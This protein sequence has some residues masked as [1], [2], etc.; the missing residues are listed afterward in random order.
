MD[1]PER[2]A[3]TLRVGALL[4]IAATVASAQFAQYTSPGSLAADAKPRHELIEEGWREARWRSGSFRL[5]PRF[6]I[7]NVGY[8]DN[9]LA[10]F[11][12]EERL[13]DFHATFGAGLAAYWRI[14]SQ[15][16]ATAF[17]APEYA[18]WQDLDAL[19]N[20]TFSGGA[21][22]HAFFNRLSLSVEGRRLERER[23]LNAELEV[24]I[25]VTDESASATF[26]LDVGSVLSLVT[27]ASI[28]DIRHGDEIND[29][30][31]GFDAGRL[32]RDVE[33][34]RAGIGFDVG[35]DFEIV[36]GV[37]ELRTDFLI[38]PAGRSSSGTNPFVDLRY[39]GNRLRADLS[40]VS[41]KLEFSEPLDPA[42]RPSA[43]FDETTGLFRL[44]VNL[45]ENTNL[46]FFGGRN[47]VYSALDDSVFFSEERVGASVQRELG[48][49]LRLILL[50]ETGE[51]EFADLEGVADRRDDFSSVGGSLIYELGP[52]TELRLEIYDTR[53][54][55][56]QPEFDRSATRIGIRLNRKRGIIPH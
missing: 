13:S 17:A 11:E 1:V 19:R 48:T 37:E 36:L 40:A 4:W 26:E 51:T 42:T 8:V 2:A 47:L 22:L 56:N 41:R 23:L 50:G 16:Y 15:L 31:E 28:T 46:N 10:D 9:V 32:D 7:R 14:G 35:R 39:R 21:G 55:S 44:A 30:L 33:R 43:T 27:A 54:D 3:K 18:W 38:D 12:G 49:R 34:L 25:R 6:V 29:L 5:D 24:P 52:V 45:G 20:F 53:F